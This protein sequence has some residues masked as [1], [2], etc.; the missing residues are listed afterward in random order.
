MA[1]LDEAK[2][3]AAAAA[4]NYYTACGVD[5]HVEALVGVDAEKE[6][7][8]GVAEDVDIGEVEED[9]AAGRVGCREA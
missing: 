4:E 8:G 3:G 5:D 7:D 2:D 1:A 9:G 6:G